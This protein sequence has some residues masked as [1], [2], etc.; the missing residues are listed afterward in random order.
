MLAAGAAGTEDIHLDILRP[1]VNLDAVVDFR[2]DLQGG[3]GGVP[4]SGG[5][6]GGDAHQT[7]DPRLALEIAVQRF[8]R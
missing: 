4:P 8:R 7:M 5:I 6:E 3:E 2:Q 1:D